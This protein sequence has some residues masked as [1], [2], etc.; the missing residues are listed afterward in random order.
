MTNLCA[1][2]GDHSITG[3]N[4]LTF[5]LFRIVPLLV[6]IVV[7]YCQCADD[8]PN[9]VSEVMSKLIEVLK[10]RTNLSHSLFVFVY[11]TG[12]APAVML[13]VLLIKQHSKI[14]TKY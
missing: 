9:L 2:Q 12:T 5:S 10:V 11:V 7:E 14:H 3:L 6:K 4:I 1:K 8:L 13:Y